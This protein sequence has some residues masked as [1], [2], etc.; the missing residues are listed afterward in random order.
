MLLANGY[1]LGASAAVNAVHDG[2]G[3]DELIE[4]VEEAVRTGAQFPEEAVERLVSAR[5]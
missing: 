1:R 2:E 5:N 4:E 3:L